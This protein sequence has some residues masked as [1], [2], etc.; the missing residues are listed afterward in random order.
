MLPAFCFFCAD[1]PDVTLESS[2]DVASLVRGW[3]RSS[4]SRNKGITATNVLIAL[5]AIV[6][7][8][9]TRYPGI[10]RAGWK[11]R[12]C[13]VSLLFMRCLLSFGERNPS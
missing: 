4:N 1:A 11:V 6:Y 12:S 9:Q 3:Q 2:R 5:N 10:T 8:F 7:A 13:H